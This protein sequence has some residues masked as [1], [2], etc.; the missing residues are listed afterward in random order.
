MRSKS[1]PA[2]KQ[3]SRLTLNYKCLQIIEWCMFN[4]LILRSPTCTLG[5]SSSSSSRC[6]RRRI[7]PSAPSRRKRYELIL[8]QFKSISNNWSGTRP[9]WPNPFFMQINEIAQFF[10]NSIIFMQMNQMRPTQ[11]YRRP[12][13][14]GFAWKIDW[15]YCVLW[16]Q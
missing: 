6:S 1:L 4:I 8:F 2:K 11:A 3:N 15:A 9:N 16:A 13:L 10:R 12:N 5:C 7:S 14:V